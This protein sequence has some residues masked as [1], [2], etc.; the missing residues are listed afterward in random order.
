MRYIDTNV[1]VRVIAGD[2]PTLAAK[3]ITAIQSSAQN[4]LCILDAVLVEV[5]FVLEF[6]EYK[7]ARADIAEALEILIATPQISVPEVTINALK[8]Y[9]QHPKLDYT[10]CLLFVTGGKAGVLTFDGDLQ[11]LLAL[12]R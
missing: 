6:H 5:C 7:M 4:E 10:D 1:L 8:L 9:K 12:S 11:E 2:N 3:A